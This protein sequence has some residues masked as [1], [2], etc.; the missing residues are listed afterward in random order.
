M[1]GNQTPGGQCSRHVVPG[2][3]ESPTSE[4]GKFGSRYLR[5]PGAKVR[6]AKVGV[7]TYRM[8]MSSSRV[9][10]HIQMYGDFIQV[11][12]FCSR[13]GRTDEETSNWLQSKFVPGTGWQVMDCD[14]K[15]QADRAASQG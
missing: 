2:S 10:A 7:Q 6:G 12:T 8:L 13:P 5:A 3:S 4:R 14:L 9:S 15:Y 1:F 11:G